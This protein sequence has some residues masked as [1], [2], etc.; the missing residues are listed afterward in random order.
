[1]EIV[2]SAF[3]LAGM[4]GMQSYALTIAVALERLGHRVTLYGHELG[5]AADVALERGLRLCGSPL[6]L[7]GDVDALIANDA[8]TALELSER[9][10]AA[11]RL[12]VAHGPDLEV[13]RP[14]HVAGVVD[15][16]VVMND[17]VQRRIAQL[18]LAPSRVERLNQPLDLLQFQD[19]GSLREPPR[20]ALLL[21]NNLVGARRELVERAC[22]ELGVACRQVGSY[23]APSG[24]PEDAIAAADVVIGYGRSVLEGM[25]MGRAAF[26]FDHVG[27]DGWVTPDSYPVL[28]AD[29]FSGMATDATF[30]RD[31]LV[32]ELRRYSA[33]MGP[34]N[35]ELVRKNHQALVHAEQLVQLL[36]ELEP[37]APNAAS[38]VEE[39]AR[40]VRREHDARSQSI[41]WGRRVQELQAKLHDAELR[42]ADAEKQLRLVTG[43]RRWRLACLVGRPL[44]RLRR[45]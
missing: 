15:A 29:G 33:E 37:G 26:V 11:L 4:G 8:V 2:V 44:D 28:E 6:A 10:P 42:A 25:A 36:R 12:I 7:P 45:R 9:L 21:G 17:R 20:E 13:N 43:S 35:R 18:A 24:T 39:M 23:G 14:P 38:A 32:R 27:G 19:V 16:V 41:A 34:L 22:A 31:R 5:T 3:H 40:L 1:M 30:D